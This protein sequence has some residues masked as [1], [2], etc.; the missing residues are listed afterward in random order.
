MPIVQQQPPTGRT[1]VSAP[2]DDI[3]EWAPI[4]MRKDGTPQG[5]LRLATEQEAAALE[6]SR[7]LLAGMCQHGSMY[8]PDCDDA[9][10]DGTDR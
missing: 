6:L 1:A 8:C 5:W 3:H 10:D 4:G 2:P 7:Y 9:Q